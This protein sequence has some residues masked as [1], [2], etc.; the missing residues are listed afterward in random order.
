MSQIINITITSSGPDLGP[1][2]LFLVDDMNN[3]IPGPTNIPKSLLVPPGYTFVVN[4]NI[5]KVRLQSIN[6]E[7]PYVE[8]NVPPP[9]PTTTTT[10]TTT[11]PTCACYY[12][13]A[14]D[15][16]LIQYTDCNGNIQFDEY[17]AKQPRYCALVGSILINDPNAIIFGGTLA[18][19]D[20]ACPTPPPCQCM[21]VTNLDETD[22]VVNFFNCGAEFASEVPLY[23]GQTNSFCGSYLSSPGNIQVYYGSDCAPLG[24]GGM[25]ICTVPKGCTTN[26]CKCITFTSDTVAGDVVSWYDCFYVY[27]TYTMGDYE[28]FSV[29]GSS[30]VSPTEKITISIGA[31]CV[32]GGE[33]VGCICAAP[34][35]T[36]TTTTTTA[37]PCKCYTVNGLYSGP[38]LITYINCQGVSTPLTVPQATIL[39]PTVAN[40]C[41]QQGTIDILPGTNVPIDNGLC[42]YGTPCFPTTTTTTAA[43]TTSTTTIAPEACAEF[44]LSGGTG[45]GRTFIYTPCGETSTITQTVAGGDEIS[46]C[47]KLPYFAAGATN[48]GSCTP[49]S[50]G[51]IEWNINGV[52]GGNIKIIRNSDNVILVN[53]NSTVNVP[54]NGLVNNTGSTQSY[55]VTSSVISG[56]GNNIK[57]RIC[58]LVNL[59]EYSYDFGTGI[60]TALSQVLSVGPGDH[61][62]VNITIGNVISP[63]CPI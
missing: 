11:L 56:S 44:T 48:V 35:T 37:P 42:L 9:P 30:P 27:H 4:D 60:G 15:G 16:V 38:T 47:I 23:G 29:C 57:M 45:Q 62:T 34:T 55:T 22:T 63:I 2:N 36:S 21:I 3:V 12:V 28:T 32:D 19:V 31:A 50:N 33:K 43:P 8:F 49:V 18:C 40:F 46:D 7:C 13:Q 39:N 61:Y 26:D 59:V 1:Y 53:Q 14:Q 54:H 10:S 6:A 58:D 24:E 52:V 17:S 25:M 5:V 51:I 20:G 41:A